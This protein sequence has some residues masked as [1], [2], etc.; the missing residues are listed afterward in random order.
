[1]AVSKELAKAV[2]QS[3]RGKGC[4]P[5][6]THGSHLQT[7]RLLIS[8]FLLLQLCHPLGSLQSREQTFT[9][10][11]R[12]ITRHLHRHYLLYRTPVLTFSPTSIKYS[13]FLPSFFRSAWW[14]LTDKV[15]LCPKY[16]LNCIMREYCS[17]SNLRSCCNFKG[18]PSIFPQNGRVSPLGKQ[19]FQLFSPSF[20]ALSLH[21][22]HED[23]LTFS[24]VS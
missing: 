21:S 23:C 11:M 24:R 3:M 12:I 9:P 5:A 6:C 15:L 16:T 4:L 19:L 14:Y 10:C 2:S 18:T 17:L 8:P 20:E 13:Y 1:M 7:W 22:H